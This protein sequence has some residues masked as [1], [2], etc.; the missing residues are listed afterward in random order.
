MVNATFYP[1]DLTNASSSTNIFEFVKYT[2]NMTGQWFMA[3][4]LVAGA[5]I[6]YVSMRKTSNNQDALLGSG[7]I[8]A[9]MAIFFKIMD[10]IST[11]VTAII[12]FAFAIIFVFSL[13]RKN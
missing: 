10:M 2:N 11:E 1:Y 8:T 6:L 12:I 3:S 9:V 4:M 5:I 13:F 7:F